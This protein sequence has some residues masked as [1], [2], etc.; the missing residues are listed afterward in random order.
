MKHAQQLLRNAMDYI[1]DAI[2]A[3]D[4]D[5]HHNALAW[6]HSA[7]EAI[8]EAAAVVAEDLPPLRPPQQ[9]PPQ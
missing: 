8:D 5:Q 1:R 3:T 2:A 9:E 7:K 4:T 6:M